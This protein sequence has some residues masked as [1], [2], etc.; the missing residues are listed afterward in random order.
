MPAFEFENPAGDV[1]EE[2]AIVR[3]RDHSTLVLLQM[4]FQPRH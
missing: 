4:P 3:D 1:I 2:V